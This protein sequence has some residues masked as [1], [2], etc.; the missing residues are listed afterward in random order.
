MIPG[1]CINLIDC[2]LDVVS[3]VAVPGVFILDVAAAA[4]ANAWMPDMPGWLGPPAVVALM[5]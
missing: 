4:A 3:V 1:C 2:P 5:I